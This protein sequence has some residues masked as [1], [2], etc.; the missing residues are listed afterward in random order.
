VQ[1]ANSTI[2]FL[3]R[4][5]T[6][7]LLGSHFGFAQ[8]TPPPLPSPEKIVDL[9][10]KGCKP[11]TESVARLLNIE[12]RSFENV[13]GTKVQ[14]ERRVPSVVVT[15]FDGDSL[16]IV[17]LTERGGRWQYVETRTFAS[18]YNLPTVS[19]PSLVETGIQEIAVN[20]ETLMRG[21]GLLESHQVIYKL[22]GGH[23][24]LV[25]D[26]AV[27]SVLSGWG[28]ATDREEKSDF[29][30][31]PADRKEAGMIYQRVTY[32]DHTKHFVA[33]HSYDWDSETKRFRQGPLRD[34]GPK[35]W[36]KLAKLCPQMDRIAR[37]AAR[38]ALTRIHLRSISSK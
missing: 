2:R 9:L 16:S 21:T 35:E 29:R 32:T 18:K 26:Q 30:Y 38:K 3:L 6:L 19:F 17:V 31:L 5:L 24:T 34:Y 22:I 1:R 25:F 15:A 4:S 14:L 8:S 27:H 11:E 10:K 28:T 13:T 23:L 37:Q 33:F 20:Q 7:I 12:C 36:D